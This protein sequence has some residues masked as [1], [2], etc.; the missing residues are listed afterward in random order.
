MSTG[1]LDQRLDGWHDMKR[2]YKLALWALA[3]LLSLA[4]CSPQTLIN[5]FV[6][7]SDFRLLADRPYGTAPRQKLDAYLP[8]SAGGA[9]PVVVFFYG[10][11]WQSGDKG[12]YLFVAE[13]L[14][15]QGFVVVIPDYRVY[16]EVRW[17][18]FLDDGA[19]AVAWTFDHIVELGGDPAQ[20]HL[21]GHSAGAY[22]AAMLALDGRW[23]GKRR[24]MIAST[25][26]LAGP[27]DFL[28]ITEPDI[29]LIFGA[30]GDLAETQ[31]ITFADGSATP[32]LLIAG[33]ADRRVNPG[34]SRRLAARIRQ[35]G[36]MVEERYYDD[37]GHAEIIVAMAAPLHFLAP[38]RDD[39]VS[40][41]RG[42]DKHAGDAAR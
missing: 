13:A 30:A 6:S 12:D 29:K 7:H 17:P 2:V 3:A 35:H 37:V 1:V 11:A 21:A 38:V 41:L 33:T 39:M 27:Y 16:P 15:S 9:R 26:G 4:G 42:G 19:A 36:G 40:F 31:P 14:A 25:V 28:P 32:M 20:V 8:S 34:N 24:A 10:G 22:I 23:L 5:G 18:G